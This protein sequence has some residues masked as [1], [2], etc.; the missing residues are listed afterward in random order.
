M[1]S[2]Q[3]EGLKGAIAMVAENQ[4]PAHVFWQQRVDKERKAL[5]KHLYSQ[6]RKHGM[7]MPADGVD[8]YDSVHVPQFSEMPRTQSTP[9]LLPAIHEHSTREAT[10]YLPKIHGALDAPYD[11]AGIGRPGSRGTV[12]SAGGR[13]VRSAGS[14][15][16]R[17]SHEQL[18]PATPSQRSS[19]RS[20]LTSL[21]TASLRREVAEAVQQEV[22]KVVQPLKDKLQTEQS[23]RQ[24][25]EE[26]LRK[27]SGAEA[28]T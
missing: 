19:L 15:A 28:G 11:A 23:T 24:R 25:L 9:S 27:A 2:P 12:R 8:P 3:V 26:M 7:R 21:T 1:S 10:P 18:A 22:A 14:R 20:S 16:P 4:N 5:N 13:S 6:Y 17:S